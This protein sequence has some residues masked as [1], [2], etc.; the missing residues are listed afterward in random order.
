MLFATMVTTAPFHNQGT[1]ICSTLKIIYEIGSRSRLGH[2]KNGESDAKCHI[3]GAS[4]VL[5]GAIG[6]RWKAMLLC[7]HSEK[8]CCQK[9][10]SS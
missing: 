2:C 3:N 8:W 1:F 7:F 4:W 5:G 6:P 9:C 10:S